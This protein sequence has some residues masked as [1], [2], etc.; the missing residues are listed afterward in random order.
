M[1]DN[2]HIL[3]TN[4]NSGNPYHTFKY[5]FYAFDAYHWRNEIIHYYENNRD[6]IKTHQFYYFRKN[7]LLFAL[8]EVMKAPKGQFYTRLTNNKHLQSKAR[9]ICRRFLSEPTLYGI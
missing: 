5:N 7:Q 6:S 3:K 1:Y 9:N 8:S 4:M 2:G